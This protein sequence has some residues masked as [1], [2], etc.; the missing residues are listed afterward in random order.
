MYLLPPAFD[1]ED[2]LLKSCLVQPQEIVRIYVVFQVRADYLIVEDGSKDNRHIREAKNTVY[3]FQPACITINS[4][5]I[6]VHVHT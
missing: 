3:L 1:P 5:N 2:A 6:E 4:I